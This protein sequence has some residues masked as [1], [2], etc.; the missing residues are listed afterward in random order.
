MNVCNVKLYSACH[1]KL[2][3]VKWPQTFIMN[4]Y[5]VR[6]NCNVKPNSACHSKLCNFE[7]PQTFIMNVYNV[8]L[9]SACHSKLCN[10]EWPQT[11]IMKCVQC[12]AAGRR[13]GNEE[14]NHENDN[15]PK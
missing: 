13:R 2:G 12:K 4:V 9:Y 6:P 15:V 8:K 11:F 14:G 3:N 10:F 7:W 1:S 5:N